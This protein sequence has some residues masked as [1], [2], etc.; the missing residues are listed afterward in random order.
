MKIINAQ[1]DGSSL[2]RTLM[3][4]DE[5]DW[6]NLKQKNLQDPVKLEKA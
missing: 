4:I 6:A 5:Q 3:E 2:K 1:K